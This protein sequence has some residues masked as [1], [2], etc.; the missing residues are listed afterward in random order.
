M[1]GK[2]VGDL[3]YVITKEEVIQYTKQKHD[4]RY[5]QIYTESKIGTINGMYATSLGTG[6]ILPISANFFP[7]NEFFNLKLTGLQQEVMK[8]S[9]HL[10]FTIAWNLTPRKIQVECR[11]KYEKENC[12]G[13][14]I[15]AGDLDVHKEGPSASIAI[16]CVIY[17]LMNQKPIKQNFG[18]T[19]ELSMMGEAMAIGGLDHKILGSIK[20]G[21]RSFIYPHENERQFKE[22]YEKYQNKREIEGVTFHEVKKIEEVFELIFE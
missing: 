4:V 15:H 17:S 16:C 13:I 12:S 7:S 19:G 11:K 14:N 18:V 20:S 21:V 9:M 6:G 3:P 2:R 10:A 22:F 1:S 5:R 8:E